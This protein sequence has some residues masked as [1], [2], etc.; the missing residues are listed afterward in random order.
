M[1]PFPC[2]KGGNR[3][4][5]VWRHIGATAGTHP[6][7]DSKQTEN[8][9]ESFALWAGGRSLERFVHFLF[10]VLLSQVVVTVSLLSFELFSLE[11]CIESLIAG[12]GR[13]LA[14]L[15]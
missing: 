4:C 5:G 12:G 1:F 14:L 6:A 8:V 9:C 13:A 15:N 3:R 11:I 10:G 2:S 7:L